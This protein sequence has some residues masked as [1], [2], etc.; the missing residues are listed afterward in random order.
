M[1]L[2]TLVALTDFSPSAEQAVA[3]AALLAAEHK[4]ELHLLHACNAMADH[5]FPTVTLNLPWFGDLQKK[6]K[7]ASQ[8]AFRLLAEKQCLAASCWGSQM[9]RRCSAGAMVIGMIAGTCSEKTCSVFWVT[10]GA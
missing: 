10:P 2:Q 9:Y 5:P 3:R 7:T 6:M 4:A 8:E 1:R